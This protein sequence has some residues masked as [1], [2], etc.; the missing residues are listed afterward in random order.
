MLTKNT[1][2]NTQYGAGTVILVRWSPD[3]LL[4][5]K[6]DVLLDSGDTVSEFV[7]DVEVIG[8]QLIPTP[9]RVR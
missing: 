5:F 2:V 3:S 9:T 8:D 4:P 1:R 6:C 7:C